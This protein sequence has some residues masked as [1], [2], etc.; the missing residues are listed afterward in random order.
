MINGI[1]TLIP[2]FDKLES[3]IKLLDVGCGSGKA[4]NLM[5]KSFPNSHFTGYDFS[6]EA[7]QNAKNEAEKLELNNMIF[8]K[9]DAA[10]F[11][12]DLHFDVITAFDAIHDQAKPD[13]VLENIKKSLNLKEYF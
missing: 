4:I 2:T 6:S 3:G 5:A 12:K 13:K 7:I 8:E 9:Q 1:L 10:S 11:S